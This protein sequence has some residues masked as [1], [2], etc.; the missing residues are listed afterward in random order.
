MQKTYDSKKKIW[1]KEDLKKER[2]KKEKLEH[3]EQTKKY[4]EEMAHFKR[5]PHLFV[6]PYSKRDDLINNR[7]KLFTRS[8]SGPFYSKK[9]IESR[10]DDFNNYIE[11]KEIE[12][13]INDEKL[14]ETLKEEQLKI[15]EDDLEF[16]TKQKMKLNFAKEALNEDANKDN[17]I[18]LNYK[19]IATLKA[20]KKKNKNKSYKDYQEFLDIVKDKQK[21]GL[22][23]I[24]LEKDLNQY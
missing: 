18:K 8:L 11:Q 22:Y 17:D 14:A 6:D 3:I 12:K 1:A 7:I 13:K 24:Y 4:L 2:I 19:F 5:T 21:R 23:D 9:K 10:I 20:T 16:Q 15:R